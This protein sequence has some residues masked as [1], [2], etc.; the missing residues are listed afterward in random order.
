MK[1]IERSEVVTTAGIGPVW[2][3]WSGFRST[4]GKTNP[5]Q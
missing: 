3:V 2:S 4:Y 1:A 5:P